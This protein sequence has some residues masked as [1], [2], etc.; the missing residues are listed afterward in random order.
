MRWFEYRYNDVATLDI[1]IDYR[2]ARLLV[3]CCFAHR[4]SA[5]LVGARLGRGSNPTKTILVTAIVGV[6][7]VVAARVVEICS[8]L[9]TIISIS[10]SS[11]S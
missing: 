8:I 2:I 5:R 7:F 10:I 6:S 4:R 1:R 11:P 9:L 3:A